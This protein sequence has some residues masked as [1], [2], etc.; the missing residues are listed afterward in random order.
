M[1]GSDEEPLLAALKEMNWDDK[2]PPTT[3][4]STPSGLPA[5]I[6]TATAM[7]ARTLTFFNDSS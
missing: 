7:R 4:N 5:M 3:F 2:Y 1:A 6:G